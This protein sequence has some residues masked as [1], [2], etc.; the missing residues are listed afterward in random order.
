M[1][2]HI[3]AW[4]RC[5][6]AVLL[7]S[8]STSI[9]PAQEVAIRSASSML[10]VGDRVLT[11]V[12]DTADEVDLMTRTVGRVSDR[13]VAR[14]GTD[15]ESYYR[16]SRTSR[17]GKSLEVISSDLV[18]RRHAAT[19]AA[20][21]WVTTASLGQP[22]HAADIVE[23]DRSSKV[24]RQIQAGKGFSNVL[25]KI[26]DPKY[27]GMDIL[28]DQDT[29]D[30]L[31]S[32][33]HKAVTRAKVLDKALPS[34][35]ASL[36]DAIN[37]GRLLN[38]LPCGAPLPTQAHIASVAKSH[39]QSLYDAKLS[40]NSRRAAKI[41]SEAIAQSD[42]LT[43]ALPAFAKHSK[44]LV[45]AVPFVA[46]GYEIVHGYS[47]ISTTETKFE[48]G[49]ISQQQREIQ[50]ARTGGRIAGGIA[51]AGIGAKAGAGVGGAVGSFGGPLGAAIGVGVG[52]VAGGIG[53]ALGGEKIV[54]DVA[55]SATNAIHDAGHSIADSVESAWTWTKSNSLSAWNWATN[56]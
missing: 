19:G 34:H 10:A 2:T 25:S 49:N 50:H 29:Y 22:T 12:T 44:R 33:L 28:T 42:E 43:H 55:E 35:F 18:N 46:T 21:R 48:T 6:S 37:Q 53:G 36:Q 30:S 26:S 39:A 52:G 7:L 9:V 11:T 51:G 54:A 15:F 20:S 40:L 45:R 47:E 38:R 24:I 14:Y 41:G 23:L 17:E 4:A 1:N 32:E 27:V 31:R 13:A 3:V 5:T 56:D 8:F 16:A